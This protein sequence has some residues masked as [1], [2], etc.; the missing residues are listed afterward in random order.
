VYVGENGYNN[1]AFVGKGLAYHGIKVFVAGQY[2]K[3]PK[4]GFYASLQLTDRFIQNDT[5]YLKNDK[6]NTYYWID[7]N[8]RT[9]LPDNVVAIE[10][11]GGFKAPAISRTKINGKTV[12][13]FMAVDSVNSA[14]YVNEN[15][16]SASTSGYQVLVCDPEPAYPCG[17]S[18]K[19]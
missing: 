8:S 13:S 6:R 19:C 15:G 12:V 7:W 9:K 3:R 11:P 18:P 10:Q 14:L 2:H 17:L 5:F 16:I 4:R 1:P